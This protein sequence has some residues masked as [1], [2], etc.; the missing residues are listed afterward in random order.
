MQE[1]DPDRLYAQTS[2]HPELPAQTRSTLALSFVRGIAQAHV[3]TVAVEEGSLTGV[4]PSHQAGPAHELALRLQLSEAQRR[5]RRKL[6]LLAGPGEAR[7]SVVP[8]A[9]SAASRMS[10]WSTLPLPFTCQLVTPPA[11]STLTPPLTDNRRTG[12]RSTIPHRRGIALR[13]L[14]P[15]LQAGFHHG[16]H[17]FALRRMDRGLQLGAAHQS[18]AGP[19]HHHVHILEMN[20]ESY[21][22]K[23]S[24]E[25]AAS[26]SPDDRDDG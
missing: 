6:R 2:D 24:R 1:V 18:V 7:A 25:S 10:P 3:E 19:A 11:W 14:Q 23:R 17:Q 15:A 8:Q 4:V 12:L 5:L 20:G 9:F 22:L 13:G 21:R 26:Q 16:N